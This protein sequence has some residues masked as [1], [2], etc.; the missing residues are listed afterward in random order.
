MGTL[1]HLSIT[2]GFTSGVAAEMATSASA[3]G[4][5][6]RRAHTTARCCNSPSVFMIS[7]PAPSST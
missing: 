6:A 7:Q 5:S 1:N 3:T 2:A 4:H